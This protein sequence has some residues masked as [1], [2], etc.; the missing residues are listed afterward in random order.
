[1]HRLGGVA[2]AAAALGACT[3]ENEAVP[4]PATTLSE[5]V[6]ACKVEPILIKQCS[7]SACHGIANTALR[8]Y[9]PG[10]LRAKKPANIDEA[11]APLTAA[12]HHANFESAAG[13]SFGTKPDDNLLLRKPLSPSK[14][15]FAHAG[16]VIFKTNDDVQFSAIGAWL[17]GKGSCN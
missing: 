12:E 14:G 9:S 17:Q 11:I 5:Q 13:F 10:K 6:F 16:G 8:V 7:Y 15:G 3:V 4:D 1:M 2:I